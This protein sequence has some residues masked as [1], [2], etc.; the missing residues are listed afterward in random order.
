M[1]GFVI[2]PGFHYPSSQPV[3]SGAFLTPE[4]TARQL[5]CQKC[6][7]V[8]GPSTRP[9]N[10]DSG[11]RALVVTM[12]VTKYLL[13]V[14]VCVCS[15]VFV[16]YCFVISSHRRASSINLPDCHAAIFHRSP[17]VGDRNSMLTCST[18]VTV[19]IINWWPMCLPEFQNMCELHMPFGTSALNLNCV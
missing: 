7:Q 16:A 14:H 2:K 19:I 5:G 6:T 3:N 17:S 1:Y 4:L 12:S 13:C 8:H 15:Q 9:V 11:N 18:T 10:A